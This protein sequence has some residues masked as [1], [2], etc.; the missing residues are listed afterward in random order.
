MRYRKLR[1]AWSVFWGFA[2]VLLIVLWVRS[3][4]S[5]SLWEYGS[6]TSYA[7]VLVM[8]GEIIVKTKWPTRLSG[9]QWAAITDQPSDWL[10]RTN[11][12]STALGFALI[13]FQG[14][15]LYYDY[16]LFV[17]FWFFVA[18]V[19]V[20]T[21]LPWIP[22]PRLAARFSLGTLLVFTTVVAAVLGVVVY[23]ARK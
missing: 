11:N 15:Q 22:R 9:G 7:Q 17:P 23:A 21:G 2:C 16:C 3:Y 4:F 20:L 14:K 10:S 6:R 8:K 5:F 12:Y 18:F 1:I 13:P 19:V